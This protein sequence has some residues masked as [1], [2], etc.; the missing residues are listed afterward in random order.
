M[1]TLPPIVSAD[2][3]QTARDELLVKEKAATRAL[4]ALAAERRRLPMV[5]LEKDY[6]LTAPDG[7]PARL[8]DL[9]EGRRQL[10]VYHFM[11]TPGSD[12]ICGGCASFTDNIPHLDHLR[13]YDTSFALMSRAPQAQ[14]AP[15]RERFGWPHPWYSS[16]G[17]GLHED[18]GIANERG[19]MFGLTAWLRD[20]DDVYRTY[21][22]TRRG[23][24][25]L[26]MDNNLL[27]L[28]ALGRQETWEDSPQGWPQR[29]TYT[30]GRLR[31]EY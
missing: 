27:D 17:S 3:W 12:H 20:G 22:T 5:R 2:E 25:R 18:L 30:V 10:V 31:D 8:L 1:M 26:R 23:V 21:F 29:P 24:D 16:H 7:A 11:L 6:E 4:D 19:D 13:A 9:F 15:V 14:I 28:T